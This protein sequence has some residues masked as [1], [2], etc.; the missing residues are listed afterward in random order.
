[1]ASPIEN[2]IRDMA[3][4]AAATVGS[5]MARHASS[6]G[7]SKAFHAFDAWTALNREPGFVQGLREV[8][9]NPAFR[10]AA[11]L[12]TA[13]VEAL[14]GE[15]KQNFPEFV[16]ILS[17]YG[18]DFVHE[19]YREA[20]EAAERGDE[21]GF[22]RAITNWTDAARS[23]TVPTQG[24]VVVDSRGGL[25]VIHTPECQVHLRERE[26]SERTE[27]IAAFIAGRGNAVQ[28]SWLESPRQLQVTS[29]P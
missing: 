6:V 9:L 22:Q 5:F 13:L 1:M 15:L 19:F 26:L 20:R 17:D 10:T 27:H 23:R 14:P 16:R 4:I 28:M 2:R 8:I 11:Q 21:P 25:S 12:G 3:R 7:A 29:T 24:E 18:Q